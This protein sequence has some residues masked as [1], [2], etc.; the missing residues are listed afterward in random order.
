MT[1]GLPPYR[2]LGRKS[3]AAAIASI[4]LIIIVAAVVFFLFR[5]GYL[6][7]KTSPVVSNSSFS[8]LPISVS[9]I[10]RYNTTTYYPNESISVSSVLSN[11]GFRAL[12][13]SVTPYGCSSI[14]SETRYLNIGM[15]QTQE[16]HWTFSFPNTQICPLQFLACFS[17]T[18][19]SYFPI[20]V[21]GYNY[22]GASHTAAEI[23]S[24][25]PVELSFSS[26]NPVVSAAP[27]MINSSHLI[28][29]SIDVPAGYLKTGGLSW[30]D[31]RSSNMRL[32]I[33]SASGFESIGQSYNITPSSLY[34][35]DFSS[36]NMISSIPLITSIPPSSSPNG[37]YNASL[38]LTAGYDYCVSSNQVSL[39]IH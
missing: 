22:S 21:E 39:D 31:I 23:L 1:N 3:Q 37:Y 18:S 2:S 16:I 20:S 38:N 29:A 24:P 28:S 30:L 32:Y 35:L 33:A 4:F 26:Y 11:S 13:A 8:P 14:P 12:S 7:G 25:A 36:G 19:S 9:A 17:Y 6:S 15:G 10:Q 5:S 34:N 27:Y